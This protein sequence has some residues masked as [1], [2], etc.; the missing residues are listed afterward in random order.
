MRLKHYRIYCSKCNKEQK[1]KMSW[2]KYLYYMAVDGRSKGY[3]SVES[4]LIENVSES[5]PKKCPFGHKINSKHTKIEF[6][7]I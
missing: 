4:S 6:I 3:Y 5:G 1:N 2:K 7:D